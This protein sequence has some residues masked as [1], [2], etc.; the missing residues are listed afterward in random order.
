ML[1]FLKNQH[2]L[3]TLIIKLMNLVPIAIVHNIDR[4]RAYRKIFHYV[5]FEQIEG[6]YLEFGVYEG[7]S[8]ISA[9]YANKSTSKND[10]LIIIDKK[11]IK[12]MFIGFDSFEEGFKYYNEKDNHINWK[13]SHLKSSFSKTIRRLNKTSK[14]NFKLVSGFVEETLKE[15]ETN[16]YMVENY[17]I[18]SAA[19]ILIDMD[20]FNPGYTALSF[21]KPLLS[22]GSIIIVDNYYNFKANLNKGEMG[23][24]NKFVNET[25]I[26]LTDFG[27]YGVTGKIFIVSE[28]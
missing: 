2:W 14:K 9:F 25:N 3:I 18:K 20:L 23:A 15:I 11:K 17:K 21:C 12:R 7:S 8:M 28:I 13:E 22:N 4:I 19:V 27:N 5:N 10:N 26:K 16:D 24:I 6:D 1:S